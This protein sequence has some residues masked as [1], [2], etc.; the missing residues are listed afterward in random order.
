[1]ADVPLRPPIYGATRRPTAWTPEALQRRKRRTRSCPSRAQYAHIDNM[2]VDG[3]ARESPTARTV[4]F[5]T[6]PIH[7]L[8]YVSDWTLLMTLDEQVEGFSAPPKK[9]R[10]YH[11]HERQ[12]A[13]LATSI[14]TPAFA[15]QRVKS[16]PHGDFRR[17][18]R[19]HG[20]QLNR[21]RSDTSDADKTVVM[22][23]PGIIQSGRTSYGHHRELDAFLSQ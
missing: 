13:G 11:V 21:L 12:I 23:S 18:V 22:C 5:R 9:R 6:S 7:I 1:M 20:Y 19:S 3:R 10:N 17:H 16:T 15:G 4:R 8:A 14:A 2:G